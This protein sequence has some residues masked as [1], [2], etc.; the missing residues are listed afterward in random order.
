M[1][2]PK[3]V[4][5]HNKSNVQVHGRHSPIEGTNSLMVGDIVHACILCC[6]C[7]GLFAAEAHLHIH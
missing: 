3:I 1:N 4:L 2:H 6:T 5:G 7:G